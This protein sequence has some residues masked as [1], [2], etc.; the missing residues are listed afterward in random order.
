MTTKTKHA[1]KPAASAVAP[2]ATAVAETPPPVIATEAPPPGTNAMTVF[3]PAQLPA[4]VTTTVKSRGALVDESQLNAQQ[5]TQAKQIVEKFDL[6]NTTA[7]LTFAA[8]P[9]QAV[10]AFLDTLMSDI[11]VRDAGIAGDMA[12]QMAWGIDLMQL[13]KVKQQISG[14]RKGLLSSVEHFVTGSVNYL[15][16]FYAAQ[17]PIKDMIDKMARNANN[18][19]VTLDGHVKKLDQLADQSV[20]QVRALAAYIAAGEIILVQ[21]RDQYQQRREV[22]LKSHDVVEA[23]K[24]RDM[25]RQIAALE[26]RVLETEIAYTN[27]GN[28][29]IPQIRMVQEAD[30]IEIQ[31]ISEQI[32]FQLPKFKTAVIMMAALADTKAAADDRKRMDE[33]EK[34]L[35]VVLSDTI[36]QTNRIAKESQ[37]DPLAKVV[38]LEQNISRIEVMIK[39]Q[40]DIEAK[41]HGMREEAHDRIVACKDTVGNALKSA[42]AA[43]AAA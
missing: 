14:V 11:K 5:R 34:K 36:A 33:N 35:D 28:V 18:R 24:L 20:V 41:T 27:A 31:N 25:G 1:A 15:L 16:N 9:Q 30:R 39:E 10:S 13:D 22:V 12:K 6:N 23:S 38:E 3:D 2:V 17:Q 37:G 21:A 40:L 26:K 32:L 8:P 43:A 4:E 29:T 19:M 42:N 7:V